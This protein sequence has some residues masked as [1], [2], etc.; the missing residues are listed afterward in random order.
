MMELLSNLISPDWWREL[1]AQMTFADFQQRWE[2][3]QQAIANPQQY[4]LVAMLAFAIILVLLLIIILTIA[5]VYFG[6]V[7]KQNEEY[8][9]LDED[10]Q[11][12]RTVDK[13][14][15]EEIL[16][17]QKGVE[18]SRINYAG[19][20]VA[21]FTVFAVTIGMGF[22]TR[23]ETF[24][25]ACHE[26][27]HA[28]LDV[29]QWPLV[30]AHERLTCVDCHEPGNMLQGVTV[31]FFPRA[32]HSIYGIFLNPD[33]RDSTNISSYGA[34]TQSSC[35]SCHEG[36]RFNRVRIVNRPDR[37]T[38]RVSHL[39][40]LEAGMT[41]AQCH[42]FSEAQE[43]QLIQTGM[44]TCVSCH[45]G[46]RAAITCVTC[47]TADSPADTIHRDMTTQFW[48]RQLIFERPDESCYR[49]HAT[50]SCDA[51]HGTR[52][53]HTPEYMMQV[54]VPNGEMIHAYD[55]WRIGDMC[56]NCHYYDN[57]SDAGP[58][59]ACHGSD[60]MP[61]PRRYLTPRQQ[62]ITTLRNEELGINVDSAVDS[63]AR[64]P[65]RGGGT[66]N[67]FSPT[68]RRSLTPAQQ[69]T[70]RDNNIDLSLP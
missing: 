57:A 11:V 9:L 45:N 6:R 28:E 56:Y 51:C 69:Q 21:V 30:A 5:M 50:Q 46:A 38:V 44:Q 7:Q 40:P 1:I 55:Y 31:N 3:I 66:V 14:T 23:T 37:V 26:S 18:T 65:Q 49:C 8:E 36:D 60:F 12:V 39:E 58:C 22:T 41:C 68:P 54:H 47:H 61:P 59:S 35:L 33:N 63:P 70:L 2:L 64:V 53:P 16:A 24:C 4:P 62:Y 13:E 42:L 52:V 19:I 48:S 67:P 20:L 25:T 29:E 27:P 17:E 15:A 34:V 43:S 32:A 10:E